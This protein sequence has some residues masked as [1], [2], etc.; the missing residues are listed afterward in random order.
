MSTEILILIL[1]RIT[2]HRNNGW[3]IILIGIKSITKKIEDTKDEFIARYSPS[4]IDIVIINHHI[5]IYY[6]KRDDLLIL[7]TGYCI[8]LGN[9]ACNMYS[10]TKTKLKNSH[11]V[12]CMLWSYTQ[13]NAMLAL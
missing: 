2:N 5:K 3:T 7:P 11:H 1:I 10:L 6:I 12:F 9:K 8:S 13:S 4:P